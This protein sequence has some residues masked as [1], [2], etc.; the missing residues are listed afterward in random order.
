MAPGWAAAIVVLVAI[1]SRLAYLLSSADRFNADEAVTGL[2]VRRILHGQNFAFY[3]GQDYGGTFEMYLQAATYFVLRLPQNALTLRFA[4]LAVSGFTCALIYWTAARMLASRWHAVAAALVFA[5]GP[6]YN[7]QD[8][9]MAMAFYTVCQCFAAAG[10]YCA[11]R[12]SARPGQWPWAIGLGLACGLAYWNSLISAYVLI[13]VLLWL[14]PVLL[15]SWRSLAAFIGSALAGAAPMIPWVWRHHT[16]IPQ[17]GD[18][19]PPTTI[20]YR[21]QCLFGPV[22]REFLGFG[23]QGGRTQPDG[24]VVLLVATELVLVVGY[25]RLC[26]LRRHGLGQLLRGRLVDRDPFDVLLLVPPITIALYLSS[27]AGAIRIDPRYLVSLYPV[28]A[29]GIAAMLPRR[30]PSW[31]AVASVLTVAVIA[32]PT[33]RYF[34]HGSW[35][36]AIGSQVSAHARDETLSDVADFLVANNERVACSGYWTAMPLQFVAGDRLTVGVCAVIQ[37]RFADVRDKVLAAPNVAY[38]IDR[39]PSAGDIGI[40][41]LLDQHNVK[42]RVT[43]FKNFDVIDQVGAGGRPQQLGLTP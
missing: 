16:L 6:Y 40:R 25:V 32:L 17:P 35:H 30:S 43:A 14:A 29:I 23:I 7:I 39:D 34:R 1:G 28:L 5:V 11:L 26:W 9:A 15:R 18:Y 38:V 31:L 3:A 41:S 36:P 2:M 12:L 37:D 20:V 33:V 21:A 24:V 8:G 4:E 42:Y 19:G 22:L 10:F 13:P 27:G